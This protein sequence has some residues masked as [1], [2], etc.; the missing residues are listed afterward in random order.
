MSSEDQGDRARLKDGAVNR[1]NMLLASTTIAAA[2]ALGS[3]R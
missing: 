3:Q 1:R 2:S